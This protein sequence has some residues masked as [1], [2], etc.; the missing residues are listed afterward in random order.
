[1]NRQRIGVATRTR[2]GKVLGMGTY[3]YGTPERISA[4]V[5]SKARPRTNLGDTVRVCV[6]YF[7]AE[8]RLVI[9]LDHSFQCV[10]H[11]RNPGWRTRLVPV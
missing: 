8:F 1:M 3:D 6:G 4:S 10:P 5:R 11:T 2:D 9:E 7:D